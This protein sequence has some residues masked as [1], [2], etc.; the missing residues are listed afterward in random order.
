MVLRHDKVSLHIFTCSLAVFRCIP[1]R[2]FPHDVDERSPSLGQ[3]WQRLAGERCRLCALIMDHLKL[4]QAFD[5]YLD[6]PAEKDKVVA[7]YI[8]VDFLNNLCAK[9]RT[10]D[11]EPATP[12][13]ECE[14]RALGANVSSGTIRFVKL[15]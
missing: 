7:T 11:H 12:D 8:F 13:G 14:K 1:G 15:S 5:R 9:A 2:G 6:L 10:L 3:S 4:Q